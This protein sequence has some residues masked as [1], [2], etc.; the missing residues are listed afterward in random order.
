MDNQTP[1]D[2]GA[3]ASDD[4][5]VARAPGFDKLGRPLRGKDPLSKANR[6]RLLKALQAAAAAGDAGA[7]AALVELSL[8][9]ER[10]ALFAEMLRALL[11][12]DA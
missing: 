7:A 4:P 12:D 8:A 6:V 5:A 2:S 1:P 9:S 10:H 11:K 3:T